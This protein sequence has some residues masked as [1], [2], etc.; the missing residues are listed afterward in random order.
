M[1]CN[2]IWESNCVESESSIN[3]LLRIFT[4]CGFSISSWTWRFCHKMKKQFYKLFSYVK[5]IIDS[6]IT[7]LDKKC[8][9]SCKPKP[10]TESKTNL[11]LTW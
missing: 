9:F 5:Q 10:W 11:T 2:S 7:F 6:N 4:F 8:T 1:C 3:V